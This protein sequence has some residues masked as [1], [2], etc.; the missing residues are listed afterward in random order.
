MTIGLGN[1]VVATVESIGAF[2]LSLLA[3]VAPL[4]AV[5]LVAILLIVSLNKAVQSKVTSKH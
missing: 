5:G 4:I 1:A 2:T 3:L